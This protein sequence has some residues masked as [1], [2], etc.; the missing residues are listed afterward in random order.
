M[1]TT[2]ALND[3]SLGDQNDGSN[4]SNLE[5]AQTNQDLE[6]DNLT[7]CG[8]LSILAQFPLQSIGGFN[9]ATV[10]S[11]NVSI[12][13]LEFKFFFPI[14]EFANEIFLILPLHIPAFASFVMDISQHILSQRPSYSGMIALLQEQSTWLSSGIGFKDLQDVNGEYYRKIYGDKIDL[15]V[16]PQNTQHSPSTQYTSSLLLKILIQYFTEHP[17]TPYPNHLAINSDITTVGNTL[18]KAVSWFNYFYA[19]F[20]QLT[21]ST[22]S[23][24]YNY[25]TYLTQSPDFISPSS[26]SSP[27]ISPNNDNLASIQSLFTLFGF[28]SPHQLSS[29]PL[30]SLC[31]IQPPLHPTL[32]SLQVTCLYHDWVRTQISTAFLPVTNFAYN[33]C[34][35][36]PSAIPLPVT[37]TYDQLLKVAKFRSKQRVPFVS[38]IYNRTALIRCA[39]PCSGWGG[40][41]LEDEM[42][43]NQIK[44]ITQS[45]HDILAYLPQ[46]S[47]NVE[48]DVFGGYFGNGNAHLDNLNNSSAQNP[49][50]FNPLNSLTVLSPTPSVHTLPNNSIPSHLAQFSVNNCQPGCALCQWRI[51]TEHEKALEKAQNDEKNTKLFA[52]YEVIQQNDVHSAEPCPEGLSEVKGREIGECEGNRNGSLDVDQPE[53][54]INN[55]SNDPL[56][57]PVPGPSSGLSTNKNTVGN[58]P[59]ITTQIPN[60]LSPLQQHSASSSIT[61][62]KPTQLSQK[63]SI[64]ATSIPPPTSPLPLSSVPPQ[65]PNNQVNL[66]RVRDDLIFFDCRPWTAAMGNAVIHGKGFEKTH[67]YNSGLEFLDIPN[68]HEMR[69]SYVEFLNLISNWRR[70]YYFHQQGFLDKFYHNKMSKKGQINDAQQIQT[71]TVFFCTPQCLI[72]PITPAQLGPKHFSHPNHDDQRNPKRISPVTIPFISKLNKRKLLAFCSQLYK[73]YNIDDTDQNTKATDSLGRII[74]MLYKSIQQNQSLGANTQQYG[75]NQNKRE[76]VEDQTNTDQNPPHNNPSH[77]GETLNHNQSFKIISPIQPPLFYP[78][79]STTKSSNHIFFNSKK[80][81]HLA[82]DFLDSTWLKYISMLLYSCNKVINS[83][84]IGKT[85]AVHCSDNLD[86]TQQ[87]AVLVQLMLDPYYRTIKGFCTLIERE[88]FHMSH[89]IRERNLLGQHWHY[90]AGNSFLNMLGLGPKPKQHHHHH[91]HHHNQNAITNG[92]QKNANFP[93]PPPPPPPTIPQNSQNALKRPQTVSNLYISTVTQSDNSQIQ[94]PTGISSPGVGAGSPCASEFG[95][96]DECHTPSSPHITIQEGVEEGSLLSPSNGGKIDGDSG[97][98]FKNEGESNQTQI[99]ISQIPSL[100]PTQALYPSLYHYNNHL[101]SIQSSLHQ[102]NLNVITPE[103]AAIN[104]QAP[105]TPQRLLSQL[106]N[107]NPQPPQAALNKHPS[108]NPYH[109]Y[110]PIFL[111]LIETVYQLLVQFPTQFEFN[112]TF[113][114]DLF[115]SIFSGRYAIFEYNNDSERTQAWNMLYRGLFFRSSSMDGGKGGVNGGGVGEVGNDNDDNNSNPTLNVS[116]RKEGSNF[117]D[118]FFWSSLLHPSVLSQ[119]YF[120]PL[121]DPET[122]K[123]QGNIHVLNNGQDGEIYEPISLKYHQ[124][125]LKPTRST[126]TPNGV[127]SPKDKDPAKIDNTFEPESGHNVNTNININSITS[128][129][130]PQNPPNNHQSRN[131]GILFAKTT[132]PDMC[133]FKEL[134]LITPSTYVYHP[135]QSHYYSPKIHPHYHMAKSYQFFEGKKNA[136]VTGDHNCQTN[137]QQNNSHSNPQNNFH[138]NPQNNANFQT[139]TKTLQQQPIRTPPQTSNSQNPPPPPPS[140]SY[141]SPAINGNDNQL[142]GPQNINPPLPT[143]QHGSSS[144]HPH[145]PTPPIRHDS[146]YTSKQTILPSP[147]TIFTQNN[148]I[149]PEL[150]TFLRNNPE[151]DICIP[152]PQTKQA[153]LG[154]LFGGN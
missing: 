29:F 53:D 80:H 107:I 13:K 38:F 40:R 122:Y 116:D 151:L 133:L 149:S 131:K 86:R 123:Q 138:S 59:T 23:R 70:N 21:L 97:V 51:Q 6:L 42:M 101:Q 30:R 153:W 44:V 68:I 135:V 124:D 146:R 132:L 119:R 78:T 148:S 82:K 137:N 81:S 120:N 99:G 134:Y 47:G 67:H 12:L 85:V 41:S 141:L 15:F 28:Q 154:G 24:L 18:N 103:Y 14:L 147:Q 89:M 72:D 142:N 83:L 145:I 126:N 112:S 117:L 16:S 4:N 88:T 71:N 49:N 66:T 20:P 150:R 26:Q 129:Q 62:I 102:A 50:N 5:S 100:H 125:K 77:F 36:Y 79:M 45:K 27:N 114:Y 33:V 48:I 110:S 25:L 43:I 111:Q 37:M 58:N 91:H 10:N 3:A 121:Y 139:Q 69:S 1:E 39:Q 74:L 87:M 8:C 105:F 63:P 128:N 22:K 106:N 31:T 109:E 92:G 93:P 127:K 60:S 152:T 19:F 76:E 55:P 2:K 118:A 17:N 34:S 7:H 64:S 113:L 73:A 84:L 95:D 143:P 75:T 144:I 11:F 115:I 90:S 108:H 52:E 98:G 96:N 136:T 61:Q 140:A 65:S 35:S 32:L 56:L 54:Y 130:Q 46:G 57:N 104:P 9:V 94:S